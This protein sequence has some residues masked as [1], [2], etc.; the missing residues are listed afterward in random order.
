M[1]GFRDMV[2]TLGSS[3][4]KAFREELVELVSSLLLEIQHE[5]RL[6]P[7]VLVCFTVAALNQSDQ[8][9]LGEKGTYFILYFLLIFQ[10]SQGKDSRLEPGTETLEE[11]HW[12]SCLLVHA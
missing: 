11:H 6:L 12:L 2:M 8:N 3:C 10:K 9:Q 5:C 1:T 7:F 4:K